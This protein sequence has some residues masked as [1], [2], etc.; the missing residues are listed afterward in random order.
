MV[1]GVKHADIE[2]VRLNSPAEISH[3]C[4]E[5]SIRRTTLGNIASKRQ[6]LRTFQTAPVER[7]LSITYRRVT[8]LSLD[9]QNPQLH[10]KKQIRQIARSIE[11][12]GFNVPVLID[13][14]GQLIAG[15]G[16]VL[17]A[18]LLGMTEVPTIMLEH[19]AEPQIRAFMI[20]DN[21][22]T[23]NSVWNERLLGEQFKALSILELDFSIDVTG[24]EMGEIDV[25]IEGVAPASRGKDDPADA[26]PDSGAK[27]QVTRAGD[28]WVLGCHRVHCGDARNDSAYSPLM[29]GRRA[30][31]VFTDPPYSDPTN[32]YVTGFGKVTHRGSAMASGEM[33]ESEFTDF[34]KIV[35]T[36]LARNSVDG[37]LQF[38][39]MDWRHSGELISVARSIYKEFENLCVWVKDNAEQGSVYRSQHELVFVFKSCKGAHRRNI[40]LGQYGRYRTNVW[41]Y[42]RV[43]SSSRR[44]KAG[45]LSD[46]HPTTIKPV[47][48][49]TDAILDCTARGDIVLD[50]FL[51]SGT[52]VIAAERTGRVCCGIELD[53]CYVDTIV[54]RWQAF[55]GQSA[56][57]ES[58]GR[59]FNQ[60]EE[61]NNG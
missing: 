22:L 54:R 15:H 24:F 38:I 45:S 9:P 18:Q 1:L 28:L 35:L 25:M 46:L 17:A 13:A 55:T 58:T 26:I 42:R 37:A 59:T 20:A 34:L 51:G 50:P 6:Q 47:E 41:H 11:S 32:G 49:V 2:H 7:S 39:C 21:R 19:L 56:I 5:D 44:T 29:Q 52:T 10:S 14:R 53:P 30:D 36:Q 3:P 61:E 31:M 60:V 23:E 12:F 8:E 43:D 27:L 33:S 16:R 48:L 57:Q 40:R 4:P